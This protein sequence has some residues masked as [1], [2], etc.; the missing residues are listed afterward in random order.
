MPARQGTP[1]AIDRPTAFFMRPHSDLAAFDESTLLG[2]FTQPEET[3][4]RAAP[5]TLVFDACSVGVVLRA[6]LFVE[7]VVGVGAM[8]GAARFVDWL[9]RF[10]LL[11]G[12]VLPATLAWLI[13]ACA[14]KKHLARLDSPQQWL[15]GMLLGALA[16]LYGCGL[17]VLMNM[18]Q[19]A[20]WWASAASGALAVV[21]AGGGPVLACQGAY[22]CRHCGAPGR[23]AVAHPTRTF[24]SIRSTAPLPWCA[25]SRPRPSR[26]WKTSASCF[27]MRWPTRP[28]RS[29]LVRRSSWPNV[30]SR[31]NKSGFGDRLRVQWS[32]DPACDAAKLPPLLLQPL[33]ENAVRHG[34]EPSA[35]G[36]Q[37]KIST[38]KR[39]GGGGAQGHQLHPR[40]VS[41]SV[42]TAW[43]WPMCASAWHC[44][45]MCRRSSRPPSRTGIFQV[46]LEIPL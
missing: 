39:G 31:L 46:R 27:A 37:V 9:L 29:R 13:A 30:T 22:P 28:S 34:V 15:A 5:P 6:V 26:C 7:A 21:G 32:L 36:A 1:S 3:A 42:A 38:L 40:P 16:G 45:M 41:A 12:G 8:F 33:V 18:L 10:S 14:L 23:A 35:A 43:R 24:C 25:P 11:T 2:G 17:L 44:C 19:P 4:V 20:P